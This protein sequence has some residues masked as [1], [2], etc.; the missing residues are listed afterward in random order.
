MENMC[1][2]LIWSKRFKE[3]GIVLLIILFPFATSAQTKFNLQ[4]ITGLWNVSFAL[5]SS[6]ANKIV[7]SDIFTKEQ[8]LHSTGDLEITLKP[9]D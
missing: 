2:K 1:H 3:P 5:Q 4:P 6:F 9:Y 8:I 7:L